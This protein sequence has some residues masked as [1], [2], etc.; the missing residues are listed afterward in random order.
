MRQP[1]GRAQRATGQALAAL[2]TVYEFQPFAEASEDDSVVTDHISAAQS[3][4]ADLLVGALTGNSLAG[5]GSY[6]VKIF[7]LGDGNRPSQG[8]GSAARCVGLEAVMNLHD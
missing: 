8:K 6:P 7:A 5:E 3:H 2:R 1:Q 4:D